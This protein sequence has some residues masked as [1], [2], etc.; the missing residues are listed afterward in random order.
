MT[1]LTLSH[2]FDGFW[3]PDALGGGTINLRQAVK[4]TYVSDAGFTVTLR[5]TGLTYD[6]DGL[7][8]GGTVTGVLVTKDGVTYSN[9]TGMSVD[10]TYSGMVL[11]GYDRENGGHQGTDTYA[12]VQNALRGDDL[13][14]GSTGWDDIRG[15]TGNDIIN[16]GGDN[17]Y[18]GDEAGN[19]SMDGGA[20]WDTLSFDEANY[21]W[22]G[23]RG[24][25]LD[26]VT[27]IAID[28]WGGTNHFINFERYKDTLFADT[29]KGS[30]INEEQFALSRGNDLVDGRGGFDWVDYGEASRW[31]AHRGVNVN[32]GTGIA[33]DSWRGTDTLANIEGVYGTA[34]NDTLAGNAAD[35]TILGGA[36]VDAM[37]GAGGFDQLAFWNVGNNN[38]PGHG[39]VI[40]LNAA[41]N[42]VDDGYGN[43][44]NAINFEQFSGSR[45]ADL[46][47]GDGIS[48][49]FSGDNDNDTLFGGGGEDFL[50]GDWGRDVIFGGL[51]N[52]DHLNGGGENDTLTGGSGNDHFNFTWDLADAGVDT[53]TD[54]TPGLDQI[55]IVPGWGGGFSDANL[56]ANQ[57]RSGAGIT[58]A[59]SGSQ[60]FIYNSTTGDLYFDADGNGAGFTAVRFAVLSNHAALT[61]ADISIDF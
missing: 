39:V 8:S 18:V 12:F 40:N 44:E 2:T 35:N 9:A 33:T 7:P 45:M 43:A 57:F 19:D 50:D 55:H 56:V 48:N 49:S 29:M 3:P 25:N 24:V 34:F 16:A 54:F 53:I 17:D 41:R 47:T 36:G 46:M 22:D 21:R 5:G 37:N 52:N 28:S 31:G 10:F 27:G 15:G 14:T 13:I 59:N 42:V 20:D 30:D 60:R 26:V 4:M 6:D 23:F 58:V 61:F 32:L 1:T 51:G 11:F 38:Q